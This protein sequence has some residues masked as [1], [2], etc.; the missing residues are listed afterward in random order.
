MPLNTGILIAFTIPTLG[1]GGGGVGGD[2]VDVGQEGDGVDEGSNCGMHCFIHQT[3][4][5]K[6]NLA[7]SSSLS[8][9]SEIRGLLSNPLIP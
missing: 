1:G 3:T 2:G 9:E 4:L 6:E 5:L 8:H 7:R